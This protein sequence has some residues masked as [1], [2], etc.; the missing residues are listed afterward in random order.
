MTATANSVI[1]S[2]LLLAGATGGFRLALRVHTGLAELYTEG[3]WS[4]MNGEKLFQPQNTYVFFPLALL[5]ILL[6][7]FAL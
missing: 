4:V 1:S 5:T 6:K 7:L 2:L 3:D